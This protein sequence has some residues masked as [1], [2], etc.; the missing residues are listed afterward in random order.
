MTQQDR[1]PIDFDTAGT[2]EMGVATLVI[3]LEGPLLFFVMAR[4]GTA[5]LVPFGI[6]LFTVVISVALVLMLWRP[7]SVRWKFRPLSEQAEVRTMQSLCGFNNCV[8]LA[9]D[10]YGLHAALNR[11]FRWLAAEPFSIPWSEIDWMEQGRVGRFSQSRKARISGKSLVVPVWL[12]KA[13]Q[14]HH[15][16]NPSRS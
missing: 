10:D 9:A 2:V 16:E 14:R 12:Y 5:L 7:W 15:F 8:R 1:H 6:L 3:G 13:A 11:P 4:Q